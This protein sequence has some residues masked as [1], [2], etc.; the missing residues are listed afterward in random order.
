MH[1]GKLTS[2]A[3]WNKEDVMLH[4]IKL[5]DSGTEQL[6]LRTQSS[7]G[8]SLASIVHQMEIEV[9]ESPFLF[10]IISSIE[11]Q[12]QTHKRRPTVFNVLLSCIPK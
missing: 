2:K 8:N 11:P 10:F 7:V 1:H 6:L 12:K 4:V 9:G 3:Y 5:L